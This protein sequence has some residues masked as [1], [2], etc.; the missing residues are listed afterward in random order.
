[1]NKT[2]ILLVNLGTP[3]SYSTKDI[4]KFL[5]EFLS[6]PRVIDIPSFFRFLLLN[7]IIL[8]FRPSKVS[9]AYKKIWTK[10]GSPLLSYSNK[11]IEKL[12]RIINNEEYFLEMA[13]RYGEPSLEIALEN[14]KKRNPKCIKI[15]PLFPQY[16]TATTSS[17]YEKISKI[18]SKWE[19]IPD[20]RFKSFFYDDEYYI[21]SVTSVSEK[22]L[23]EEYEHIIFSFHGLPEKN[24]IKSNNY[25]YC[26]FDKC[27]NEI[28][29]KNYFCY[30]AQS[31]NTAHKIA[32]K[33]RIEENK[34]S[35]SFQSRLG[36]TPWIKPYTDEIIKKLA[37]EGKKNI[38]VF[39][40]SFIN[41]CLETNYEIALEYNDLFKKLGGEKIQLV[42][43][44]NDN[45]IWIN[46]L[47]I[48]INNI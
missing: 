25:D 24:I 27:C 12:N 41:D 2:A 9:E 8:P 20:I 47:N 3:N 44:L 36:K 5:R 10:D 1:M 4:R 28:N 6:D 29:E 33:L 40:P 32:S 22:Y 26:N 23:I 19:V 13:M 7:L 31:F 48:M 18:I 39:S 14:I 46:N 21:N 38:L 37:N 45:D 34:Y 43:S 11:L 15:L 42:E 35:I 16:S 17:V 30:R